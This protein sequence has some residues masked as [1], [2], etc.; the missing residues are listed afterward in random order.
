[1]ASQNSL[2][3]ENQSKLKEKLILGQVRNK[4]GEKFHLNFDRPSTSINEEAEF[5]LD[6]NNNTIRRTY[7]IR[8]KE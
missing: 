6:S 3:K 7:D 5:Q 1:M 2:L 8:H 4:R